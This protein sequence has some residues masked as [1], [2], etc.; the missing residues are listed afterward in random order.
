MVGSTSVRKM[1]SLFRTNSEMPTTDSA[2]PPVEV[3]STFRTSHSASRTTTLA[4]GASVC[5]TLFI[6]SFSTFLTWFM[7]PTSART[8]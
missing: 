2:R 5:A 1:A 4:P 3:R 7:N 8:T 6:R